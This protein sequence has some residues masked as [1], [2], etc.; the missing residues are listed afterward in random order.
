MNVFTAAGC[1]LVP[2]AVVPT[3]RPVI[4]Y[5][6]MLIGLDAINGINDI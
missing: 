2:L 1:S 6:I 4:P 5:A 3:L